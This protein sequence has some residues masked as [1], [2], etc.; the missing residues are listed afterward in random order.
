MT[1]QGVFFDDRFMARHAG[2]IMNDAKTA[3]VE[4][5]AN[6]WDAY[7]TKVDIQWPDNETKVPFSIA[8]NGVGMNRDEFERRWRTLD[9][10]R[11]THQGEF[12]EKPSD[13]AHLPPRRAYGRNGRGRHAAFFFSSP[14]YIESWRDGRA[15]RAKVLQGSSPPLDIVEVDEFEAEG[16]GSRIWATLFSP[17]NMTASEARTV[18]GL[19]FLV[20]PNFEVSLNGVRVSFADVPSFCMRHIEVPVVGF[21]T[22]HIRVIDVMQPDKTT[23]Q[24]G[25][26]WWVNRRLVGDLDWQMADQEKI[27]DGRTEEAKRYTFIVSADYLAPAVEADWSGFRKHDEAWQAT[28]AVVQESI[29]QL[30]SELT[31][32]KRQSAKERVKVSYAA[33]TGRMPRLSRQR[34]NEFVDEVVDRCPSLT[35]REVEQVA[36]ILAKLESSQSQYSILQKLHALTPDQIDQWD[37]LLSRWTVS[38]ASA[39]LDEIEWRLKLI[40]EIRIKTA[41]SD[42]DEVRDLQPLFKRGLWIFGPQFESIDYTSNEGMTTVIRKIF[43]D[44]TGTGSRNRPDFVVLPESSVGLYSRPGYD[45]AAFETGVSEL[46][47]VELKAPGVRITANEK[48]QAWRYVSELLDR[49]YIDGRTKVHCFVLGKELRHTDSGT[50]TERDGMVRITPMLYNT[51]VI[52]AERRM[53]NLREKLTA[54]GVVEKPEA[55]EPMLQGSFF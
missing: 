34:W 5:V 54:L 55:I 24:H 21:G 6:S 3:L 37:D 17:V 32:T 33:E 2:T 14:Y 35:E 23:K 22:S 16:H 27:I 41:S 15:F 48:Q 31:R 25:I 40:E 53:L 13:L 7:A 10:N 47:I 44:K 42:T 28:Q 1:E 45:D 39:V 9:Y 50:L 30:L 11:L 51:F 29:S 36:G 46:V 8:D 4:L 18:L 26:A 38:A 52:S 43:G 49:G 12:A 20:D 19:R